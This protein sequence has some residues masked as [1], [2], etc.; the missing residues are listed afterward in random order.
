MDGYIKLSDFGNAIK[1]KKDETTLLNVT[2]NEICA[3][4]ILKGKAHGRMIDWWALG[5][6]LF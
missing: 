3:P 5:L 2:R 1:L 6:I 4:E